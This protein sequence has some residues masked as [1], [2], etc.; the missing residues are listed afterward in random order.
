MTALGLT[1]TVEKATDYGDI[2]SSGV[3]R[4]PGWV[5]DELV[6]VSGRVPDATEI[7]RLLTTHDL[8]ATTFGLVAYAPGVCVLLG[9]GPSGAR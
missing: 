9:G 7:A 5:V 3:M 4:T 2:A 6:L 8:S 1:A